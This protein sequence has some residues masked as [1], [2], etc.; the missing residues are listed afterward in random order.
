MGVLGGDEMSDI[1][2]CYGRGSDWRGT[3]P[4][5]TIMLYELCV[6]KSVALSWVMTAMIPSQYL[7]DDS[8]YTE[9]WFPESLRAGRLLSWHPARALPELQAD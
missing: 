5:K 7:D 1:G 4:T 6:T 2:N 3:P 9:C 8:S